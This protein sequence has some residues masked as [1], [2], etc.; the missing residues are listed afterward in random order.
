V[1]PNPTDPELSADDCRALDDE[2]FTGDPTSYFR[3]KIDALLDWS[4][5]SIPGEQQP[6]KR[7]RFQDVLGQVA[8]SRY[9]TT[10]EQRRLQVAVD[11]I[12]LRHQGAEALLR[13]IYARLTCRASAK[14]CSLWMALIQTPTQLHVL[15]EELRPHLESEDFFAI[16]AGMIIPVPKGTKL[17]HDM[18]TAVQNALH[19]VAR[20]AEIVSTGNIDLNAANNK[21]KHGVTARPEDKLRLTL[22]TQP[23]DEDGNVP[24]SA[25]TSESALDIFDTVVLEYISRPPKQKGEE[26]CGFE[27]TLLRADSPVVLAEAWMLAVIHGAVFHTCAYRHHGERTVPEIAE[28]P[29]LAMGPTPQRILG[30]HVVGMRFPMTTSPSGQV[31]RPAGMLLGDGTFLTLSFGPRT[32][33]IVIGG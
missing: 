2:F 10:L 14:P 17:D 9:P 1:Y 27:R 24:L 29:G 12:Q 16:L 28:H 5:Q 21:I 25:L 19:W 13:L 8:S 20:A 18:Q 3:S 4:Q 33:G 31:H 22:T 30:R 23:P 15:V 11:A 26:L 7:R 6:T 32:R